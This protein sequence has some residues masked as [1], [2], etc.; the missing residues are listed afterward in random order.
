MSEASV[1]ICTANGRLMAD[2]ADTLR[3]RMPTSIRALR[4]AI[5]LVAHVRLSSSRDL[6]VPR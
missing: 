2:V 3:K 1:I 6:N 5:K 4:K